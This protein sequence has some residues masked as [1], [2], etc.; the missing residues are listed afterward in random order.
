MIC[1]RQSWH[2][3]CHLYLYNFCCYTPRRLRLQEVFERLS[4][5]EDRGVDSPDGIALPATGFMPAPSSQCTQVKV[6][7]PKR[8][9]LM[10]AEKIHPILILLLSL[11]KG[12]LPEVHKDWGRH[13]RSE[14]QARCRPCPQK[15][16]WGSSPEC[17]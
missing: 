5:F 11:S 12:N 7:N 15:Y 10:S 14:R 17:S 3:F 8:D 6:P 13:L 1:D 4:R 2:L 16:W 9:S